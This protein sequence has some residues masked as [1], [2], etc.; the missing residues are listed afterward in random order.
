MDPPTQL[1]PG[2]SW[3]RGIDISGSSYPHGPSKRVGRAHLSTERV[4]RLKYPQCKASPRRCCGIKGEK[5]PRESVD[6]NPQADPGF[7]LGLSILQSCP[8]DAVDKTPATFRCQNPLEE[9]RWIALGTYQRQARI[10]AALNDRS[11]S[12]RI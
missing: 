5:F 1:A 9:L 7:S 3:L 10:R 12:L 8:Q 4:F 2:A 11:V 6:S